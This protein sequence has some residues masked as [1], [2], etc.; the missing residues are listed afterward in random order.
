MSGGNASVMKKSYCYLWS[1]QK[2]LFLG[3]NRNKIGHQNRNKIGLTTQNRNKRGSL[4]RSTRPRS[5]GARST[6]ARPRSA[7]LFRI[8]SLF[9]GGVLFFPIFPNFSYF[10]IFFWGGGAIFPIFPNFSYFFLIFPI[11]S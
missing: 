10:S 9:G 3:K 2:Y 5:T 6:G 4:P 8:F 7:R 11:F 1:V